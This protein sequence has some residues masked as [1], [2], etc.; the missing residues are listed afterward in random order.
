[1]TIL[2]FTAVALVGSFSF[3]A[4]PAVTRSNPPEW[5][6]SFSFNA[7]R[8]QEVTMLLAACHLEIAQTTHPGGSA[9]VSCSGGAWGG[10]CTYNAQEMTVPN[11]M[12]FLRCPTSSTHCD[13]QFMQCT[14]TCMAPELRKE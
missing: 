7:L 6:K 5:C 4:A 1:M 8:E 10:S 12:Q 11:A 14:T 3:T 13:A 9:F 2:L